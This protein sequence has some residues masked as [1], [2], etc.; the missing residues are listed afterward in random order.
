[1]AWKTMFP[2]EF[3]STNVIAS[4]DDPKPLAVT[5]PLI[6]TYAWGHDETI[7]P[8]LAC[9]TVIE[10]GL[11]LLWETEAWEG[12]KFFLVTERDGPRNIDAATTATTAPTTTTRMIATRI[13]LLTPGSWPG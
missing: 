4:G 6:M 12:V 7:T 10:E 1:M 5:V 13:V 9:E 2:L 8:P 11:L 3:D